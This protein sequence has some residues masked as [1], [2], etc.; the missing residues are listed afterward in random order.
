MA[1]TGAGIPRSLAPFF[2]EYQLEQLDPDRH[3]DIIIE[4]VLA[5]GNRSEVRWLIKTYSLN[6]VKAWIER[7]GARRLPWRR[8]NLWSVLFKLPAARRIRTQEQRIWP[9]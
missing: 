3:Q 8:Y 7:T 5:Y 1:T 4:R 2:Q 9:H 6:Q